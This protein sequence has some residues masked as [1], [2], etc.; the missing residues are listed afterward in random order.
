MKLIKKHEIRIP[1]YAVFEAPN[2]LNNSWKIVNFSTDIP[3]GVRYGGPTAKMLQMSRNQLLLGGDLDNSHN[4][5]LKVAPNKDIGFTFKLRNLKKKFLKS[6]VKERV[7]KY[8]VYRFIL[9]Y[10]EKNVDS[11]QGMT[12]HHVGHEVNDLSCFQDLPEEKLAIDYE[13]YEE[14]EEPEETYYQEA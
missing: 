9:F 7:D 1:N 5:D 6:L 12:L 2:L 11:P 3:E 13:S 10:S 14:S 4:P 8:W